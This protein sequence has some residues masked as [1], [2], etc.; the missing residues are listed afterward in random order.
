MKQRRKS[1]SSAAGSPAS[2]F[3]QRVNGKLKP[4][5]DGSGQNSH[6]SSVYYDPVTSLWKTFPDSSLRGWDSSSLTFPRSGMMRNGVVSRQPPSEPHISEIES[7]SLL[8]PTARDHSQDVTWP[9]PRASDI[10][11][12]HNSPEVVAKRVAQGR[13]TVAEAVMFPTPAAADS[14]RASETYMRGNPT[15]L[16]AARM[17][18]TPNVPNGGRSPA[19]GKMS[20]T[21]M[22]LDGKK[23]Q[24]DL[25]QAAK[26][27]P[28]PQAHDVAKGDAKRVGRYGTKHGGRNLTDEVAKWPTPRATMSA[29]V[30]V[31]PSTD[32]AHATGGP[33]KRL[34]DE[35]ARSLPRVVG[36]QL[37][38]DWVSLLMG[39]LVDW[40]VVDGSVE[41]PE[42]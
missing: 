32:K 20:R 15:L 24:V 31:K 18:P 6:V 22:T 17:W 19:V 25:A 1:T 33:P 29:A 28:T 16:G 14:E 27:W 23:R 39:F 12:L 41:S 40:T 21:G 42:R 11:N 10:Q 7:S 13:A 35:V 37:N 26:Q 2:Q 30:T 38:A 8:T 5:R 3:R 36:G 4:I 9:T 34:E